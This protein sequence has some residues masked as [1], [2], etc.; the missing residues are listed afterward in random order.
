V[1]ERPALAFVAGVPEK[2]GVSGWYPGA[3]PDFWERVWA[4]V[5]DRQDDPRRRFAVRV[6]KRQERPFLL[7]HARGDVRA[8]SVVDAEGRRERA[9]VLGPHDG[10]PWTPVI[11]SC[12]SPWCTVSGTADAATAITEPREVGTLAAG[13]FVVAWAG[14]LAILGGSALFLLLVAVAARQGRTRGTAG[15]ASSVDAVEHERVEEP[16]APGRR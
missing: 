2:H 5:P 11:A 9:L 4:F 3:A 1:E 6:E 8:L 13:A 7:F 10:S 14:H 15:A 16:V 12:S